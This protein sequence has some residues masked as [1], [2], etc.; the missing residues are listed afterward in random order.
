M[1][2]CLVPCMD[3]MLPKSQCKQQNPDTVW[4]GTNQPDGSPGGGATS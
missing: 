4:L 1:T 3:V 2:P